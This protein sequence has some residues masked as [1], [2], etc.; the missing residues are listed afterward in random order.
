MTP[1]PVSVATS[2]SVAQMMQLMSGGRVRVIGKVVPWR[3][4]AGAEDQGS[5]AEGE[6][7]SRMMGAL[8]AHAAAVRTSP[9]TDLIVVVDT[10]QVSETVSIERLSG[11]DLAELSWPSRFAGVPVCILPDR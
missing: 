8:S 1:P 4:I 10:R 5:E 7:R 3:V 6:R 2:G 11:E 9:R